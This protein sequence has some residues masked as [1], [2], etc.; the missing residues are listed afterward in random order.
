LHAI[1][2]NAQTIA[3]VGKNA[4][5][6]GSLEKINNRK[7]AVTLHAVNSLNK[8]RIPSTSFANNQ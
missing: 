6:S 1:A 5:K 7:T 4:P 3:A 8:N 2:S